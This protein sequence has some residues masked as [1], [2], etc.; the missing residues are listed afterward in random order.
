M[1]LLTVEEIIKATGGELLSENSKTFQGVSINSRTISDGEIFFAIRG[2]RFDGHD[3]L[4]EALMKGSGAVVDKLPE[5]LPEGKT[6]ISV[7][8]ALR[9]LQDLAH[10]IRESQGIPVV[11]ITGSNG[12]TSTKEMVHLILSKKHKVLKNEGN[13][14]NHIGLPLSLTLL[15]QDQEMAVLEMGMNAAGEIRRLC[16]IAAPS[17][18]VITNIGSAHVGKLGSHEAVRDA[19]LEILE[20]L[21]VAVVNADDEYLMQGLQQKENFN[22]TVVRFAVHR[23]ADIMAGNVRVS[24]EGTDFD[25]E[26]KG[27]GSIPVSLK[28][29]GLCNVYNALA[30]AA[31]SFSLGVGLDDIKDAL[32]TYR[33]FPMRFEVVKKGG[34]TL[35]NDSYNA[36]PVSIKESV[37]ELVRLST[38]GRSVAVLGDMRELGA[39]SQDAH[40]ETG[41]MLVESGVDVFIAV[42]EKM[43]LAA[44]EGSRVRGEKA[45]PHIVSF[46]DVNETSKKIMSILQK[47]DTVLLKGSRSMSMEKI[48]ENITNAV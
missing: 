23:D 25:L 19:K 44:E 43:G 48:M 1:V 45:L 24:E 22:G 14:N 29:Q 34:V 15:E 42:G 31:V 18:G 4:E 37:H 7:K 11:A 39:F 33:A 26:I 3:Y 9:S 5:S 32:E 13:L 21:S 20:G 2:D 27:E 36:N 8:D 28:V 46:R 12:K 10:F 47:G 6:V 41:K 35:I 30:A 38:G 16:E 17:H 40:R